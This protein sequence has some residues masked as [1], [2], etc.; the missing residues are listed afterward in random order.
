MTDD[1]PGKPKVP[2]PSLGGAPQAEGPATH[3][4]GVARPADRAFGRSNPR[5][6]F[7]GVYVDSDVPKRRFRGG[8]E[9]PPGLRSP[10]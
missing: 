9:L 10:P 1:V 8:C 7:P 5:A 6:D 4:H 3:R 2:D